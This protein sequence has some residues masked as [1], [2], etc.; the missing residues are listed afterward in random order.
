MNVTFMR[1]LPGKDSSVEIDPSSMVKAEAF[2]SDD[3]TELDQS[4]FASDDKNVL[5][6]V[7]EC[8]PCKEEIDSYPVHEM[9][10]IISGSVTLTD[11]KGKSETFIAGD[12][13]FIPKGTQCTW[14]ITETLRKIYMIAG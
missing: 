6:G 11:K 13:F 4:Y 8:A 5:A 1:I 12:V 9:M 10:T 3:Q 7:W 2:T 14:H